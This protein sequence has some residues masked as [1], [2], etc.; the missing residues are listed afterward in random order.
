MKL[1]ILKT[2]AT[3]T[4]KEIRF[5]II[6]GVGKGVGELD[7]SGQR[8]KLLVINKYWGHYIT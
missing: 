1:K 6:R 2:E 5:V 7:E 3:L 8:D 4:E